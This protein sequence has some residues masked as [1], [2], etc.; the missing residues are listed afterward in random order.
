LAPPIVGLVDLVPTEF[1][2]CR[3]C[4]QTCANGQHR[5]AG[6]LGGPDRAYGEI[7]H[8][9]EPGFCS[10]AHP[11]ANCDEQMALSPSERIDLWHL[12]VGG[13]VDQLPAYVASL[14]A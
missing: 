8:N 3:E 5:L 1:V 14:G 10:V 2:D 4:L 13:D 7:F 6:D 11:S 12:A 9:C